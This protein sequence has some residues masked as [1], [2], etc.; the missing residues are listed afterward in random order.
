MTQKMI[1]ELVMSYAKFDEMFIATLGMF[2]LSE[3]PSSGILKNNISK[4][5]TEVLEARKVCEDKFNEMKPKYVSGKSPTNW[6]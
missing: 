2:S 1:G 6:K 3:T 4:I 5:F